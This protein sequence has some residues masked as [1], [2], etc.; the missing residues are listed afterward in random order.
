M[1]PTSPSSVPGPAPF[2][3]R[4]AADRRDGRWGAGPF[5]ATATAT[6]TGTSIA[7]PHAGH[8]DLRP[9]C[10]SRDLSFL[11]HPGHATLIAIGRP[12]FF[13]SQT[14]GTE[15]ED[16]RKDYAND[17]DNDRLEATAL[18]TNSDASVA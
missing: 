13:R 1:Y 5:A 12:L 9:A 6:G 10:R 7:P 11:P 17:G 15:P 14:N 16:Q 18:E 4:A 3:S 2:K 8:F